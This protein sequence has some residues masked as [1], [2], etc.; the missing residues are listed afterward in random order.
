MNKA[1][2]P[3]LILNGPVFGKMANFLRFSLKIHY[4]LPNAVNIA[5]FEGGA[6]HHFRVPEVVVL[7]YAQGILIMTLGLLCQLTVAAV[8]L[9]DGN[10]VGQFQDAF[11]DTLQIVA[12]AGSQQ[13]RLNDPSTFSSPEGCF[14]E[15]QILKGTL[16]GLPKIP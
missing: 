3:F 13:Q 1:P 4:H 14:L 11:L 15:V 10:T 5:V 16:S 9:V 2:H 7:E 6:Q 12:A 8:G